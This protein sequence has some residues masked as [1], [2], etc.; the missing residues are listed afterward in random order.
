VVILVK[1]ED[2]LLVGEFEQLLD[3]EPNCRDRFGWLV[4]W[5]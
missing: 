2:E 5:D 4:D 1:E 3:I